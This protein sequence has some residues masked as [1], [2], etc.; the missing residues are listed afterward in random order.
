M[1][2]EQRI[3]RIDRL[4]Q[5]ADVLHVLSLA[6]LNTVED[7]VLEK[8]YT[9]IGICERSIGDLESLLGDEL[10][11]IRKSFYSG[12]L[13]AAQLEKRVENTAAVL[14]KRTLEL[15]ALEQKSVDLLGHEDF[16]RDEISRVKKLGRYLTDSQIRSVINGYLETHH[17]DV[18]LIDEGDG[19][20]KI[21]MKPRLQR[22]IDDALEGQ[23]DKILALRHRVRNGYLRATT[24]GERAYSDNELD[25]L[26][27]SHPL[28]RTAAS[29]FK[30]ILDQPQAR[31]GSVRMKRELLDAED[32][33]QAG[34]YFLALFPI[35]L[36]NPS[37]SKGAKHLLEVVAI[38][39]AS[40]EPLGAQD[41][42]RLLH[43]CMERGEQ[44]PRMEGLHPMSVEA[45]RQMRSEARKRV[46]RRE[47][48]ENED[49]ASM[50]TR[51]RH[52]LIDERDRKLE[53]AQQRVQ[54]LEKR[55][56]SERMINVAR[57]AITALEVRYEQMLDALEGREPC[58][59][60]MDSDPAMCCCIVIE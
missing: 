18:R 57:G 9:R 45:W 38:P 40:L 3:G 1:V 29:S 19:V 54:T 43:L 25:I 17:A 14:E 37:S 36:S 44:P 31:I 24:D 30:G 33:Y 27:A 7:R 22:A 51:R 16:I 32:T 21:P 6:V 58:E 52:R 23:T 5:K 34:T 48:R 2:V 11:Q 46:R 55:N 20:L 42:E 10:G 13:T 4:G 53:S 41:A 60:S 49:N 50:Y 8:L 12:E 15:K 39:S 35:D 28:V 47:E 26:N 56:R 59:A